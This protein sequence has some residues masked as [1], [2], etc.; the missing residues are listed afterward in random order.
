MVHSNAA[1]SHSVPPKGAC[2]S[3]ADVI[4][5]AT[6]G[7]RLSTGD[8]ESALGEVALY[9]RRNA[10]HDLMGFASQM[11]SCLEVKILLFSYIYTL[12]SFSR[13][14]LQKDT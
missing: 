5:G 10:L 1:D 9:R 3:R 6:S 2:S 12:F 8:G 13:G 4:H 14:G 7:K 11:L